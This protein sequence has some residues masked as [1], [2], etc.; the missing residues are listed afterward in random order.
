M[1]LN[2]KDFL[3]IRDLSADELDYILKT[4]ETMKFVINQK[5]KCGRNDNSG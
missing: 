2:R 3:G 4:A 1:F 5:N